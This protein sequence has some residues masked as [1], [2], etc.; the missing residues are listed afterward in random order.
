MLLVAFAVIFSHRDLGSAYVHRPAAV[1]EA[2]GRRIVSATA[3][4]VGVSVGG[5]GLWRLA[6]AP[7]R[8]RRRV[9]LRGFWNVGLFG[10]GTLRWVLD[11][12]RQRHFA[13]FGRS[14]LARRRAAV[15]LRQLSAPD[16]TGSS[17]SIS[18]SAPAPCRSR[19]RHRFRPMRQT[20]RR[21]GRWW[22][23]AISAAAPS[24]AAAAAVAVAATT[25]AA[26]A[27]T[28]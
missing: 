25:V 8:R 5:A 17:R 24:A 7:A 1:D 9:L 10:R 2:G 18:A 11:W 22:A 13:R 3:F 23:A 26:A 14:R 12:F 6:A 27:G 15:V 28:A 16:L 19:R 21:R 4:A 20:A